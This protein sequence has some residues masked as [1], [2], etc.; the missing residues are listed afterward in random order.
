MDLFKD[1]VDWHEVGCYEDLL[2]EAAFSNSLSPLRRVLAAMQYVRTIIVFDVVFNADGK[3]YS[4]FEKITDDP[5]WKKNMGWD[6]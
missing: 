2:L 3:Y 5:V 4:V 1:H 6:H